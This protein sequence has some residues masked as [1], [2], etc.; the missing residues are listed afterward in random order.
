MK[1]AALISV[2]AVYGFLFV[3]FV[4]TSP[5]SI[6]SVGEPGVKTEGRKAAK[7]QFT[8]KASPEDRTSETI[9][10]VTEAPEPHNPFISLHSPSE[11]PQLT[12]EFRK[13][14]FNRGCEIPEYTE[15]AYIVHEPP[16]TVISGDF[17]QSGQTDWA[18]VC[19][20][21]GQS[22]I[23]IFWG[24]PTDCDSELAAAANDNFDQR[25]ISTA[26][27]E[28]LLD[29]IKSDHEQQE[30]GG[31]NWVAS[32]PPDYPNLS[33]SAIGDYGR[34]DESYFWY[35]SEGHWYAYNAFVE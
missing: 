15:P 35:C 19:E 22:S 31:G 7:L 27:S 34:H 21:D 24:K 5:K 6:N 23:V 9:Q 20:K 30:A 25:G 11:F 28:E 1:R 8:P 16:K 29:Q 33:H 13:L 32:P 14:L 26:T 10:G 3:R 12:E 2:I 17:A 18:V 4:F